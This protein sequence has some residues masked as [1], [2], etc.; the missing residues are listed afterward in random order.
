MKK[1]SIK[2]NVYVII[3][4]MII[5]TIRPLDITTEKNYYLAALEEVEKN[6][7]NTPSITQPLNAIAIGIIAGVL[8]DYCINTYGKIKEKST[9]E[10]S[11]EKKTTKPVKTIFESIQSIIKEPIFGNYISN[12]YNAIKFNHNISSLLNNTRLTQTCKEELKKTYLLLEQADTVLFVNTFLTTI[13]AE[14][15]YKTIKKAF[16]NCV[17]KTN[18]CVKTALPIICLLAGA[19]YTHQAGIKAVKNELIAQTDKIDFFNKNELVKNLAV[20]SGWIAADHFVISPILGNLFIYLVEVCKEANSK[21]HD[22]VTKAKIAKLY[23]DYKESK[24]SEEVRKNKEIYEG[25]DTGILT[26]AFCNKI[27]TNFIKFL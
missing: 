21:Q 7:T 20:T 5:Q 23:L 12:C 3:L 15:I 10:N 22:I 17:E 9:E 19:A 8:Y 16:D 13:R 1:Y 4:M 24:D 2:K 26:V 25:F 6:N 18:N 11:A 27:Y 14:R